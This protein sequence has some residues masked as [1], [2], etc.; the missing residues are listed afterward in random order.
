MEVFF[1]KHFI[2][3]VLPALWLTSHHIPTDAWEAQ[4]GP[5]P[6]DPNSWVTVRHCRFDNGSGKAGAQFRTHGC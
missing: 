6:P 3:G 5:W 2:C 1:K 4:A